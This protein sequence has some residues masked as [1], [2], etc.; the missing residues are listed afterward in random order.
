MNDQR[1]SYDAK[2]KHSSVQRIHIQTAIAFLVR[3]NWNLM[4]SAGGS[5]GRQAG[6][7][8]DKIWLDYK[9][10][11]ILYMLNYFDFTLF[12]AVQCY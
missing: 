2:N 10:L 12:I 8:A 3:K 4:P 1:T 6:R 9:I 5:Y 7:L 11:E